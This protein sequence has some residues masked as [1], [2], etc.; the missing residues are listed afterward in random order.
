MIEELKSNHYLQYYVIATV[1]TMIAI[2]II[3]DYSLA[4]TLVSVFPFYTVMVFFLIYWYKRIG[5]SSYL[6][7]NNR[8]LFNELRSPIRF[9]WHPDQLKITAIFSYSL[10]NSHDSK[11]KGLIKQSKKALL[12][13][14]ISFISFPLLALFHIS[15]NKK[16]DQNSKTIE[17]ILHEID[18]PKIDSIMEAINMFWILL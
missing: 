9:S 10:N 12:M 3:D 15:A 1:L 17:E 13:T 6:K 7:I 8:L 14:I 4:S 11:I 16:Y 5:L 2:L 18:D